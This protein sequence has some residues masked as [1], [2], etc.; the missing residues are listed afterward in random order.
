MSFV[1]LCVYVSYSYM[2]VTM[3]PGCHVFCRTL[4]LHELFVHVVYLDDLSPALF[5]D[6]IQMKTV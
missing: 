2:L 1:E 6:H 5:C 3:R 4:F